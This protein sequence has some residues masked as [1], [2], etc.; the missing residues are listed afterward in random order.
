MKFL[1]IFTLCV[2]LLT[3]RPGV[4]HSL[5]DALSLSGLTSVNAIFDLRTNDEKSLQFMFTVIRDTFDETA[6]QDV[7][8]QYIVSMRGST[9]KYLIR[10]R[11][12]DP[13]LQAE[14]V[15]LIGELIKRGIRLEACGYALNLF[16]VEAEDLVDGINAVGNS[17]NS[18]IGYQIK[19]FALVPMY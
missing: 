4:A 19:G 12:V 17:L 3:I 1:T 7:K 16:G 8:P 14:T 9:V 5:N 10:S 13:G 6:K 18:V 11:Q 15:N 2:G